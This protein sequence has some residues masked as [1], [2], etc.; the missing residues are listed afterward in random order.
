MREL[1]R[2]EVESMKENGTFMGP[3]VVQFRISE[4]NDE[5]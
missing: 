5:R 1:Q 3:R 2:E 4:G